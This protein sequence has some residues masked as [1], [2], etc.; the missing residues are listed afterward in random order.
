[1]LL[2]APHKPIEVTDNLQRAADDGEVAA[3]VRVGDGLW[4]HD[5]ARDRHRQSFERQRTRRRS[6]V[7]PRAAV[8]PARRIRV[9]WACPKI[10]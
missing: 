4:P 5:L 7:L 1:M 2:R 10:V 8:V 3:S 9:A 6:W